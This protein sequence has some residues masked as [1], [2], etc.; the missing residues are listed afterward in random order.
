MSYVN[1][2]PAYYA[3][4]RPGTLYHPGGQGWLQANVTG[5]GENPNVS[6]PG[7]QA[8]DGLGE[9]PKPPFSY[10]GIAPFQEYIR[11]G[12]A[13]WG[14]YPRGPYQFGGG[15]SVCGRCM[16]LNAASTCLQS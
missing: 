7:K 8:Q 11:T 3:A 16:Y 1:L 15:W 10:V 14:S 6:W 12:I 2:P 5:W 13:P 9:G 4:Q